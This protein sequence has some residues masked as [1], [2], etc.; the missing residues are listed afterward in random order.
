MTITH[1]LLI[2]MSIIPL[3][4]GGCSKKPAPQSPVASDAPVIKVG[5]FADGHIT[6]DGLPVTVES[7]RESFKKLAEQKGTVWYYREGGQSEPP[8][9]GMEVIKAVIEA[10]LPIR[11]SSRPDYSD[12]IGPDGKP[13][14][15]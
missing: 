12:S 11:L 4:V 15:Q 7:L 14:Q 1:Y 10:R 3:I 8:P 9:Q 13:K 5:V 2:L 6:A